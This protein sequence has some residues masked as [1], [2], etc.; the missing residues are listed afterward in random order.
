[1]KTN[2]VLKILFPLALASIL[3]IRVYQIT[4]RR[5]YSKCLHYPSCSNYAIMAL[6]KYNFISAIKSVKNRYNDCNPFSNRPF[7]DYP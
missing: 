1:M 2:I 7:I 6:R 4:K 3:L 5:K